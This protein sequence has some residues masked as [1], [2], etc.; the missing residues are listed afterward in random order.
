MKNIQRKIVLWIEYFYIVNHG[1]SF[2]SFQISV[3]IFI[4]SPFVAAQLTKKNNQRNKSE[5]REEK[6]GAQEMTDA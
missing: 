1:I 5:E 4:F 2:S 3:F 6:D